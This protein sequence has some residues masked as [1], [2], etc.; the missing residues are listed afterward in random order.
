MADFLTGVVT[1]SLL[2]A[3]ALHLQRWLFLRAMRRRLPPPGSVLS[4]GAFRTA[5]RPCPSVAPGAVHDVRLA[6]RPGLD[7]SCGNPHG[8]VGHEEGAGITPPQNDEA[9]R[10]VEGPLPSPIPPT[11]LAVLLAASPHRV[12][13]HCQVGDV[14]VAREPPEHRLGGFGGLGL[15]EL[16]PFV[17]PL[18][19]AGGLW[20]WNSDGGWCRMTPAE[21]LRVAFGRPL[22][23]A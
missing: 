18:P 11:R 8:N 9:Q 1:G 19:T 7:H 17:A 13:T 21:I 5:C 16:I 2:V 23:G 22:E 6:P 4:A 14:V 12:P 3:S 15:F 10:S 20:M